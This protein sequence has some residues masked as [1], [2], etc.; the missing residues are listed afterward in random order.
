MTYVY[1]H[2]HVETKTAPNT[3]KLANMLEGGKTPIL[4]PAELDVLLSLACTHRFFSFSFML[5]SWSHSLTILTWFHLLLH[6]ILW[7]LSSKLVWKVL[8]LQKSHYW[9]DSFATNDLKRLSFLLVFTTLYLLT[10]LNRIHTWQDTF[11]H[12]STMTRSCV[13]WLFQMWHDSS[14]KR[15]LIPEMGYTMAVYPLTPLWVGWA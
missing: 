2:I 5:L 12:D 7:F 11:V 14:Y 13:T 6:L 1:T 9:K 15:R 3:P 10:L 4:P 8:F